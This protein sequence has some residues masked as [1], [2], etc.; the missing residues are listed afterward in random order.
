MGTVLVF[1]SMNNDLVVRSPRH[2]QPGETLLGG[3][4]STHQGGKGANQAVAAAVMG[5]D[6]RMRGAVGDDPFGIDLVAAL[7]EAGIDVA[8]V[9]VVEGPSGVAVI[10]VDDAGENTIVVA[11]GANGSVTADDLDLEGVSVLLAQLEVPIESVRTA[12]R[13]A[14]AM[15]VM[16]VLNAAPATVLDPGFI[17]LVDVLIVNEHELSV[18]DQPGPGA[19]VLTLG[20]RGLVVDGTEVSAH[21]VHV[22]DT[23]GAGDACC[24]AIAAA[25]A[26][27]ASLET[28]ARLGNAAGAI[29][30]TVAGARLDR[31]AEPSIR[32]LLE[33]RP[34]ID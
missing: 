29:A 33:P 8:D 17:A 24:G 9:G 27:G 22:V 15:G 18:L 3:P 34:S 1:G 16:T 25:L 6:V 30:C 2:P 23:T 10:T 13:L 11:P 32:A 28:A 19:V 31:R 21:A 4:F 14:K 26:T 20:S 5:A 7:V 12:L